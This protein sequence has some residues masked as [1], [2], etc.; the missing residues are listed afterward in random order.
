MTDLAAGD[1]VKSKRTGETGYLIELGHHSATVLFLGAQMAVQVDV[2]EIEFHGADEGPVLSPGELLAF[3]TAYKVNTGL[4]NVLYGYLASRTIFRE[5]QFLPTLRFLEGNSRR[6]LIADEVGL[7]KTIE[8]GLILLELAARGQGD[9]VLFVVPPHLR[10]KWKSELQRRF[11]IEAG[12]WS[13]KE[14]DEEIERLTK[15]PGTVKPEQRV[16]VSQH[17][18]SMPT[19]ADVSEFDVD[20]TPS[21]AEFMARLGLGWD[22]IVI[23]EAHH[24]RNTGTRRHRAFVDLSR[25]ADALLFLTATP[26]NLGNEDLFNLLGILR[27]DLFT[28]FDAFGDLIYP[29]RH[30]GEAVSALRTRD[31]ERVRAAL[32]ELGEGVVGES[33]RRTPEYQSAVSGLASDPMLIDPRVVSQIDRDIKTLHPLS[34]VFTRTRKRDLPQ[35][36]AQRAAKRITVN[37]TE[38]EWEFYD[39]LRHY[40]IAERMTSPFALVMPSRQTASC[41]PAMLERLEESGWIED[42]GGWSEDMND[43]G[44][45]LSRLPGGQRFAKQAPERLRLAALA[46]RGIDTKYDRFS[47]NLKTLLAGQVRQVLLFSFFRKTLTY[48]HRRL[49]AEGLNVR[50]IN[51]DVSLDERERVI[52][53]FR[54][55]EFQILLSS[56]VGSEGLDFEFVG[57][58]VN[59]DLPWNPMVVE[60]RIGRLDRFGQVHERILILNFQIPGTIETD[61]IDRLYD[62]IGVFERSIGDLDDIVGGV[63]E[64]ALL[65]KLATLTLTDEEREQ[66]IHELEVSVQKQRLVVEELESHRDVLAASGELLEDQFAVIKSGGRYV[67]PAELRRLVVAAVKSW[68]PE[69]VWE[70]ESASVY[71]MTLP[72]RALREGP[73]AGPLTSSEM[74]FLGNKVNLGG[75]LRIS[76]DY[77]T[78]SRDLG[79][80]F[81]T[82]RHPLVQAVAKTVG[83]SASPYPHTSRF[84]LQP[85]PIPAGRYVCRIYEAHT[86]S[87]AERVELVSVAFEALSGD[88]AAV[89]ESNILGE[90]SRLVPSQGAWSDMSLDGLLDG[91]AGAVRS[92]MIAREETRFAV[93]VARRREVVTASHGAKRASLQ[94]VIRETRGT[95]VEAANLARL[96]AVDQRESVELAALERVTSPTVHL[97]HLATIFLDVRDGAPVGSDAFEVPS[98][99]SS[100]PRATP[101]GG[102]SGRGG[103]NRSAST[104]TKSHFVCETCW[105]TRTVGQRATGKRELC[106]DCA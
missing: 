23:D 73:L 17:A 62:R 32:V 30:V 76:F 88:R 74:W 49:S 2:D 93:D 98:I 8:A 84:A 28:D 47:E 29:A 41:I 33:L 5:Y 38:E 61:I 16:I 58:L 101:K 24:G 78:A 18:I 14:I 80:R 55:G 45:D 39:A 89:V 102:R 22:L 67:D 85:G 54:R 104:S 105:Q 26:L 57:S 6:L 70:E 36:F 34:G 15:Y 92:E 87:I 69:T 3:L 99:E 68:Y 77:E 10:Q 31:S 27:P 75:K 72:V 91:A 35:P 64:D 4:S 37:W 81:L 25:I 42:P 20:E 106:V 60:Q 50:V 46:V 90:L 103:E 43:S 13:G 59:Y 11:D 40:V 71:E 52:E 7:G 48:L 1:R 12:I 63:I 95:R 82:A 44:E 83:Q 51:G 100:S 86:R 65:S 9:R 94:R 56:E 21:R 96:R 79:I 97:R 66:L 19:G 53:S